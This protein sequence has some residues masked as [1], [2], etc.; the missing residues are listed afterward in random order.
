MAAK[1]IVVFKPS[2]SQE[3][4]DSFAKTVSEDGK[5]L[6]RG[7]VTHKYSTTL[8]GFAATL[9]ENTLAK[10]NSLQPGEDIIDYIEPDG[11]VTTQ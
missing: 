1:Y 5:S 4:I 2:A 9:T 6:F 8:K 3:Q 7:E 10:F 11:V